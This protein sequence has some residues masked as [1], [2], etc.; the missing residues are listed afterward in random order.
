[1]VTSHRLNSRPTT[2][3][4]APQLKRH[5]SKPLSLQTLGPIQSPASGDGCMQRLI[6]MRQVARLRPTFA[7]AF[8]SRQIHVQAPVERQ[9][10]P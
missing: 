3:A 4:D 5:N 8:E 1:M 9:G 2:I 7:G 6:R 10:S